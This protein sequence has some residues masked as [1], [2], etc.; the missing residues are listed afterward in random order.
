M[1][2]LFDFLPLVLFFAAYRLG[3]IYAATGVAMAASAA[4]IAWNLALRR[5]VEPVQW[6]G[7]AVIAVFGGA[8]LLLHNPTFIKWKPTV[9]YWCF[10]AALLG[11]AKVF[12]RNLLEAMM[13]SQLTLPPAVWRNL[14]LAWALFFVALGI[15]NLYVAFRFAEATW[16][17]FKAFGT[18]GLLL[19]FALGQGVF[20]ARHMEEKEP[21]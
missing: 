12:K 5:R 14:N 21:G 4:Q 3:G 8:T 18:T 16:V 9:L 19:A 17:N 2:I 20:L 1:K 11:S 15:A 7:L 13:K 6:V 10:A